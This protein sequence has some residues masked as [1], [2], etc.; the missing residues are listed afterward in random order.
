MSVPIFSPEITL[1]TLSGE[2]RLRRSIRMPLRLSYLF[3]R[4]GCRSTSLTSDA[5]CLESAAQVR[6][7]VRHHPLYG[8][9]RTESQSD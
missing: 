5:T 9:N 4:K 1:F 2:V 3:V 7:I 8:V 6:D